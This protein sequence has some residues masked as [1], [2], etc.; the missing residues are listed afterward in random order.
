MLHVTHLCPYEDGIRGGTVDLQL[1]LSILGYLAHEGHR[2]TDVLATFVA[3]LVHLVQSAA[4][5]GEGCKIAC[6]CWI[7]RL[8]T[9]NSHLLSGS[10][11]RRVYG[12]L[13][14]AGD[15]IR[16]LKIVKAASG[17]PNLYATWIKLIN[18]SAQIA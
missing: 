15:T 2:M 16:S 8:P 1:G 13:A 12:G 14:R 4:A 6:Q 5:G 10:L 18:E 3:H 11:R 7:G 17:D 9:A